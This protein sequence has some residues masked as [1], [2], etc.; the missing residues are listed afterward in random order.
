MIKHKREQNLEYSLIPNYNDALFP[1]QVDSIGCYFPE[2]TDIVRAVG[3]DNICVSREIIPR[4]VQM[5]R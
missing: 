3:E 4:R 1:R 2:D 5:S